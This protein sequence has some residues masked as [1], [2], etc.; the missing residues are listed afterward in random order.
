MSGM[1]KAYAQLTWP[2]VTT[3]MVTR[4]VQGVLPRWVP[5]PDDQLW[6]GHVSTVPERE[7]VHRIF[8]GP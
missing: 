3:S 1:A 6:G 5:R 7:A 2:L 4:M 8:V